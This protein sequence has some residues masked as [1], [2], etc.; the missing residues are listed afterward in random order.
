MTLPSSTRIGWFCSYTPI[1]IILAA[2]LRPARVSGHSQSIRKADGYMHRNL[3]PYVRSCLDEALDGHL[4]DFAG[5]VFVNSCDAMRRLYDAWRKYV[6]TKFTFLID[7]P[8]EQRAEDYAYVRRE[9]NRFRAALETAFS[10]EISDDSIA[11]AIDELEASR[12]LH[13]RLLDLRKTRPPRLGGTEA[14]G[15]SSLFCHGDFVAWNDAAR[16]LLAGRTRADSAE[17]SAPAGQDPAHAPSQQDQR[18]PRVV[19]AGSPIHGG[20]TFR[21]IEDCGLDLVYDDVC[22]GSRLFDVRVEKKS[23][24][25][26]DLAGAYLNKPPCARMLM[27]E[28][29]T[30]RLADLVRE[31]SAD[32]VIY[33]S[34][35]FCDTNLYDA[36]VVKQH[37]AEGGIR[38]LFIESDGTPGSFGQLRTRIEAFGEMIAT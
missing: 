2:G 13:R 6:G 5:V 33:H 15:L 23:D 8:R 10:I 3:C 25:L 34:L 9:L 20:D 12:D 32:G 7:L 31:F 11:R 14:A 17:T 36:P 18:R 28:E 4:D 16:R 26:L 27:V 37:L 22:S 35:K 19:L 21:L 24:V 38:A 29:R 1:E 30:R